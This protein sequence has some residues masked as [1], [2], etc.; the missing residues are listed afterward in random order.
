MRMTMTFEQRKTMRRTIPEENGKL[1]C[2]DDSLRSEA[3]RLRD[4]EVLS[5][6]LKE[7]ALKIEVVFIF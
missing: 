6:S 4:D 1:F 3:P 7:L 2:N 5:P